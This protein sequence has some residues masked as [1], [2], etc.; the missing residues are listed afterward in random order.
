MTSRMPTAVLSLLI[1][2]ARRHATRSRGATADYFSSATDDRKVR[3]L[4]VASH[5][6]ERG[7]RHGNYARPT[8][9]A[10]F[11]QNCF[12][13]HQSN[14]Q[15]HHSVFLPSDIMLNIRLAHA[16]GDFR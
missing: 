7:V 6:T 16:I 3:L 9:C 4:F 12:A 8:S 13:D 10:C 15:R 2:I 5:Y 14:Q 11:C 1:Y